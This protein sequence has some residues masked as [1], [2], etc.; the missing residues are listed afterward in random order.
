[1]QLKKKK[2]SKTFFIFYFYFQHFQA[3]TH[4]VAEIIQIV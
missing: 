4:I 2:K 3:M 1:M